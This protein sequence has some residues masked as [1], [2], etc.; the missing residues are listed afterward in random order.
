MCDFIKLQH[1]VLRMLS[2]NLLSRFF[3]CMYVRIHFWEQ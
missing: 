2:E 1:S 3:A